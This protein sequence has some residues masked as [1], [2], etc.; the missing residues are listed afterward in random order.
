MQPAI[1]CNCAFGIS[2][3]LSAHSTHDCI[4]MSQ[5]SPMAKSRWAMRPTAT[6]SIV[7]NCAFAQPTALASLPKNHRQVSVRGILARMV[8]RLK[9][10]HSFRIL[11]Y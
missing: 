3:C 9:S 7:R 11:S 2:L 4:L 1:R 8:D 10:R 6:Q 5:N